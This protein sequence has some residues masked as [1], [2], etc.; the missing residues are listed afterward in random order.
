MAPSIAPSGPL[1]SNSDTSTS[2]F[3]KTAALEDQRQGRKKAAAAC[4]RLSCRHPLAALRPQKA[5]F[6]LCR[7]QNSAPLSSVAFRFIHC[8]DILIVLLS[9]GTGLSPR[10][11][12]GRPGAR[13]WP[14]SPRFRRGFR[15]T[16][17]LASNST[18]E[19]K[20]EELETSAV[21]ALSC[22]GGGRG[23][24]LKSGGKVDRFAFELVS[25][26]TKHLR[27]IWYSAS[28]VFQG[29]PLSFFIVRSRRGTLNV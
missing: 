16:W 3:G 26:A 18:V 25:H 8:C 14:S 10:L 2:A 22:F 13:P 17:R 27:G 5:S 4:S 11:A 9:P 15:Q 7:A 28:A 6:G 29:C 19:Q 1:T 20:H 23:I 21:F 12:A 24:V